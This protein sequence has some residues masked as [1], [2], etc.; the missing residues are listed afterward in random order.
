[1]KKGVFWS[2]DPVADVARSWHGT[3]DPRGC[4]AAR[5]ATWQG[6]TG[7]REVQVAHRARTRGRRPRGRPCGVPRGRGDGIWR[8]P[9]V[10]GPRLGVWGGNAF[11]LPRPKFYMHDSLAF[12][13]CRTMFP[14]NH[15]FAGNVE[16][17]RASTRSQGVDR[18]DRSPRDRNHNT[19]VNPNL[20]EMDLPLISRHVDGSGVF[21]LHRTDDDG[22]NDAIFSVFIISRPPSNGRN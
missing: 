8:A 18:M 16:A 15:C 22:R 10:S 17:S 1:M 21:D 3:Q 9:R 7:P 11:A 12:I 2:I 4:D 14:R 20:S 5:K 6:H 19:C 13:P